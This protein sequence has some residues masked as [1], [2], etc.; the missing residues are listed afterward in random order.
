MAELV[1]QYIDKDVFQVVNGA[2]PETTKVSALYA[3]R[4][5]L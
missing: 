5:F 2:I 1:P 3:D 4:W